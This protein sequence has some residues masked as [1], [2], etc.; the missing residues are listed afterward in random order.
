MEKKILQ[1]LSTRESFGSVATASR[2]ESEELLVEI[3]VIL[4]RVLD[5][6]QRRNAESLSEANNRKYAKASL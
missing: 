4:G 5:H 1:V 3:C 2:N 6:H